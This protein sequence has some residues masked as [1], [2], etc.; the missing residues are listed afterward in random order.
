MWIA[1]AFLA[2]FATCGFLAYALLNDVARQEPGPSR[3]P[4]A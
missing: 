2:G 4:K 3:W 1:V